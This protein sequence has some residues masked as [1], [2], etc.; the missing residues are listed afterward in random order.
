MKN[1]SPIGIFDSGVGG[2]TVL[3]QV[4][5]YLPN[6]NIVY[7]GDTARV[8]YGSKSKETIFKFS[9]QIINFLQQKNVKAIIIACNSV[10][11]NCYLKILQ[12]FPNLPI[13]EVVEPGVNSAIKITKNN[14]IGI[15]GTSATI[16][17]NEYSNK[18][19]NKLPNAKVFSKAC[20]LFVPLVEE[21]WFETDVTK[22]IAKLYLTPFIK[23]NIDTLILGCTHYPFLQ[24][25]I[26]DFF[27][28]NVNIVNPAIQTALQIKHFLEKNNLKNTSDCIPNY[29]FFASDFNSNF[30]SICSLLFNKTF[31]LNKINIEN[32]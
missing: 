3:K 8:P 26:D 31:P 9:C 10:S 4:M 5:N 2:L 20:P 16:K 29:E 23:N 21:G 25:V 27:S 15:I 17:S 28:G 11:S 32:Y 30:D 1:N 13:I 6:E 12:R 22:Q 7:F 19:I 24:K 18:I 14:K